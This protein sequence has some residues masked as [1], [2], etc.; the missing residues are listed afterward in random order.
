MQPDSDHERLKELLRGETKKLARETLQHGGIVP[1]HRLDALDS[2]ERL[3]K[4]QER[5]DAPNSRRWPIVALLAL[6]LTVVS[7]LIFSRVSETEVEL[8]LRLSEVGLRLDGE[9]IL[10]QDGTNLAALTVAGARSLSIR[11]SGDWPGLQQTDAS[12]GGINLKISRDSNTVGGEITMQ[13]LEVSDG[14]TVW[15]QAT[16]EPGQFRLT[17]DDPEAEIRASLHGPLRLEYGSDSTVIDFRIPRPA[18]FHSGDSTLDLIIALVAPDAEFLSPQIAVSGLSFIEV[19]QGEGSDRPLSSLLSGTVVFEALNGRTMDLVNRQSLRLG[20]PNGSVVGIQ[21]ELGS[22][23]LQF[24]GT[25][26]NLET[27]SLDHSRS[28]M[29]TYLEW[30]QAR[31]GLSLFWGVS[32]YVFGLGSAVM[33]W[34]RVTK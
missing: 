8:D 17:L 4:V 28:L 16:R 33:R 3:V 12:G 29:P 25:V 11:G 9:Q 13:G 1:K 34:L 23:T 22:T 32:L 19:L 5:L 26:S 21:A 24:R 7:V 31:H 6:T 18:V 15:L 20:D 30:T 27:G 10:V 2:L 14:S